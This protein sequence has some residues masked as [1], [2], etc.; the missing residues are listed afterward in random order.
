MSFTLSFL[1]AVALDLLFGDPRRLAHPVQGIG[2]FCTVFEARCRK[3]VASPALAG[4]IAT[5]LVP[6]C[7]LAALAIPL[8]LLHRLAPWLETGVALLL[9]STAIACRSLYDHGIQVYRALVD[10]DIA[11]ARRKVAMIVGR[12]TAALD[13]QGI[14]R[15]CVE[16]VAENLV[17]GIVAPVFYAVI[18]SCLPG[19]G[20][21]SPLSLAVLGAYL[22]KAINTMDS[23]Y[24]YK[25]P[26]YLHFGRL[27]AR[28]DDG[29]NFLPARLS[30][31][32]LVASA[33]LLSRD[34]R[35]GWR[36]FTRDRFN[37]A[38]PN[39]GHPEAAMAGLLGVQLGGDSSYFGTVVSKP[40]LGEPQRVLE[41]EDIMVACRLMITASVLFTLALLF[42]RLVIVGG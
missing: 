5:I 20:L 31:P 22:Y 1:A 4:T 34:G 9:L 12:D 35:N 24:G 23:M 25:N 26:T 10:G 17:D 41:L 39:S 38:S 13:R 30:G 11:C 18:A 8:M 36:I 33:W 19:A 27:A 6:F 32:L 29:A 37:H 3:L 28:I 16:T 42:C 14:C 40:T 21:L 15:A 2:W 7:T